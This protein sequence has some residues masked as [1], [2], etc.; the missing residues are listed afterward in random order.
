[1]VRD[2]SSTNLCSKCRTP[3]VHQPRVNLDHRPSATNPIE[4]RKMINLSKEDLRDYSAEI[5]RLQS[6]PCSGTEK[7]TGRL[8]NAT[9]SACTDNFLKE[10]PWPLDQ[11]SW[12]EKLTLGPAMIVYLPTLAISAV[13]LEAAPGTVSDVRFMSAFQLYLDR[14]DDTVLIIGLQTTGT[15]KYGDSTPPALSLLLQHTCRWKTFSYIGDYNLTEC[16]GSSHPFPVLENLSLCVNGLRST[17][18]SEDLDCFAN[19]PNL[20]GVTMPSGTLETVEMSTV[21]WH[22]LTSMFGPLK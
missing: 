5:S 15:L 13:L 22:Q 11:Y 18:A 9:P 6:R 17:S 8:Q 14:S 2:S 12:M 20:Y 1:M 7:A 10:Y 3:L 19:A 16:M 4:I 21:N